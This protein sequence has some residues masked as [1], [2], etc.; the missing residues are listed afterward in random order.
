MLQSV[1]FHTIPVLLPNSVVDGT[2]SDETLRWNSVHPHD[3]DSMEINR[4]STGKEKLQK[5]KTR[6]AVPHTQKPR[7]VIGYIG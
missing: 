4:G 7:S 5:M 1:I 2:V 3:R 6:L